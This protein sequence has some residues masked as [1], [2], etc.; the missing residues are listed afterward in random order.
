MCPQGAGTQ[1]EAALPQ[2]QYFLEVLCFIS[3]IPVNFAFHFI[4]QVCFNIKMFNP[5]S[6]SETDAQGRYSLFILWF[7]PPSLPLIPSGLQDSG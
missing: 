4:L 7:I 1:P 6:S 3:G 2:A 5:K